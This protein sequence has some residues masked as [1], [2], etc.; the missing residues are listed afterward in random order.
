MLV[1]CVAF[2]LNKGTDLFVGAVSFLT[3]SISSLLQL[4]VAT[5]YAI[6]LFHSFA[7]VKA[8]GHDAESAMTMAIRE[9]SKSIVGSGLTT[10]VGFMALT[11]M[12]FNIGYDMGLSMAKGVIMCMLSVIVFMPSLILRTYKWAERTTHRS[13]LPAFRKTSSILYRSRK[14]TLILILLL[15]IPMLL[16]KSITNYSFGIDDVAS[17]EG[18]QYYADEQIITETFGSESMLAIIAPNTDFVAE[19]QLAESLEEHPYVTGV[20]SL[21]GLA[22]EGVPIDSLP[23]SITGQ[24]HT[25]DYMR[26]VVYVASGKSEGEAVYAAHDEIEA[27][28][29]DYYPDNSYMVGGISATKDIEEILIVDYPHINQLSIIGVYLVMALTFRSLILPLLALIPIESAIIFNMA[30]PYFSGTEL[31]YLGMVMVSCILLGATVD[32]SILLCHTYMDL[33]VKGNRKEAAVEAIRLCI[34]TVMTSATIMA[35][36]GFTTNMVSDLQI[37]RDL[38]QL[39]GQGAITG[40]LFVLI[41]L[42][43]LLTLLDGVLQYE[44]KLFRTIH[45]SKDSE[46]ELKHESEPAYAHISKGE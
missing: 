32:Y 24:L 14:V 13:F 42:P 46:T 20:I 36:V 33:R 27:I 16:A 39:I 17:A 29:H 22:P 28:M 4:A 26:M 38:G 45:P 23:E 34:P 3:F 6:F 41:L 18:T 15:I 11:L 10:V 21:A 2:I 19:K 35:A 43:A 5:A 1:M 44:K 25:D 9:A 40:M 30:I 12:D 37:L 31:M 7:R 8:L